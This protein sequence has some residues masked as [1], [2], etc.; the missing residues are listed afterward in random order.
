MDIYYC[1]ATFVF[2][3]S[4]FPA[5]FQRGLLV[6]LLAI[7]ANGSGFAPRYNS[8]WTLDSWCQ[9][10]SLVGLVGGSQYHLYTCSP[11][12][13]MIPT[14]CIEF[15]KDRWLNQRSSISNC[16]WGDVSINKGKI[17]NQRQ[18]TKNPTANGRVP[19]WTRDE[20]ITNTSKQR[21]SASNQHPSTMV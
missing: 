21:Q 12:P 20:I 6:K 1:I 8:G 9:P 10:P 16:L 5:R 3:I 7:N 4:E 18:S 2:W 13:S 14:G 15:L 19:C 17:N 11:L